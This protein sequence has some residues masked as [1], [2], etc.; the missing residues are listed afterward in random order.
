MFIILVCVFYACQIGT[1]RDDSQNGGE[2]QFND[3]RFKD[4]IKKFDPGTVQERVYKAS[5][6]SSYTTRQYVDFM[7]HGMD[8]TD[9]LLK[10][11][12]QN[13]GTPSEGF[14]PQS[15]DNMLKDARRW[16]PNQRK[17]HIKDKFDY[18]VRLY[19]LMRQAIFQARNEMVIMQILR[20]KYRNSSLYK[21]GFL[22]CKTDNSVKTF[23]QFGFRAFKQ[24]GSTRQKIFNKMFL[25]DS[26]VTEE[27]LVYLWWNTQLLIE[28]I[29]TNDNSLKE[30]LKEHDSDR[31]RNWNY[32]D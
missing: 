18:R 8:E 23:S 28:L 26:L 17:P 12:V 5:R 3:W 10:L 13:I 20:E 25:Y 32:T 4:F 6:R 30:T 16:M 19:E 29:E 14:Q 27:R 31:I 15:I 21:M 1:A 9:E 22:F 7:V 24:C 2:Q 11:K